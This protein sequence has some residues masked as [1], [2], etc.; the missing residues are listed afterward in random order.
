MRDEKTVQGNCYQFILSND[1]DHMCK[2]VHNCMAG[3]RVPCKYRDK[4]VLN[5]ET[6]ITHY[7]IINRIEK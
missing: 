5:E 2:E 1:Y 3:I 6:R 4:A 7:K